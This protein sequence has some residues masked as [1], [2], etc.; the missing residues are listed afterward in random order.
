MLDDARWMRRALHLARLGQRTHPNPLVGAVIVDDSKKDGGR[1]IGEGFHQGVGTPHAEAAAF[2]D[3]VERF[4]VDAARGATIYVTLEPCSHTVGTHGEPRTP[5]AARCIAAGVR[6]VVAAMEDPDVRVAGRGFARL[7]AVGIKVTVGVEEARA[8]AL[9]AAYIHHRR[10]GLPYITHKAALTLDGKIAATGGDARWITGPEARAYVHRLRDR[11]DAL[12]VGVGTILADD[13][14]LTTRLPAGNGHDP[15]RVVI[16]SSLRAPLTARVARP[17]T[18]IIA[19]EGRVPDE[20]RRQWEVAGVEVLLL[21][22]DAASGRVDVKSIAAALGERG[23]LDVL[24]ESGG[25]LAA[26]FWD[27]G[28]IAKALF[29]V[30]PKIIGGRDAPTPVGGAGHAFMREARNLGRLTT[31]H[32]GRDVAL[33]VTS[34]TAEG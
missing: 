27:V 29:F 7:R 13:P 28:L 3:A 17:G 24:L 19:V 14:E 21:P 4:G 23:L 9:N 16:D 8:R 6:R 30:A 32:F 31:R 18:L 5:C 12:I 22:P 34:D 15:L 11:A 33:E 1:V 20:K 10:T 25:E 2:V 26:S